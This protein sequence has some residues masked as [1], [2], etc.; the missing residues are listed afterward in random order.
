MIT[1]KALSLFSLESGRSLAYRRIPEISSCASRGEIKGDRKPF[2]DTVQEEQKLM[3]LRVCLN[4]PN[5]WSLTVFNSLCFVYML[6]MCVF[7]LL[8]L[9]RLFWSKAQETD[10][11]QIKLHQPA[12]LYIS[13]G[14]R[15]SENAPSFYFF[16][17]IEVIFDRLYNYSWMLNPQLVVCHLSVCY[18]EFIMTIWRYTME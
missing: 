7:S 3:R 1:S 15:E 8:K 14:L 17:V 5:Q 18:E 6:Y 12:Q 2:P 10:E 13:K 11:L 9:V 16:A 4:L